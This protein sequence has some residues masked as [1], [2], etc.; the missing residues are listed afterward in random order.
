VL[1]RVAAAAAQRGEAATW[2]AV[3][4]LALD[5]LDLALA[6][7]PVAVADPG[8]LASTALLAQSVAAWLSRAPPGA[9]AHVAV[10]HQRL[11]RHVAPLLL[12]WSSSASGLDAPAVISLLGLVP[13]VWPDASTLLLLA[14]VLWTGLPS[15]VDA[16]VAVL[17]ATVLPT[18]TTGPPSVL[19]FPS[20]NFLSIHCRLLAAPIVAGA[21]GVPAEARVLLLP[22]VHAATA[23]PNHAALSTRAASLATQLSNLLGAMPLS[24]VSPTC[25]AEL[26]AA[27]LQFPALGKWHAGR[28]R[29]WGF[30]ACGTRNLFL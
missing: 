9:A 10:A 23:F 25:K 12:L 16:V 6:A 24:A 19:V 18:K 3:V 1:E 13:G 22:L 4:A 28:C 17:A 14:Y 2:A 20:C 11:A 8:Q 29:I 7:V 21:A 5:G 27:P 15:A 26:A 30:A